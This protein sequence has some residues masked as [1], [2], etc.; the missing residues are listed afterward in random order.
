[1]WS[2]EFRCK[3]SFKT[4][5][6]PI[7]CSF[8]GFLLFFTCLIVVLASKMFASALL[9]VLSTLPYRL[10]WSLG[11]SDPIPPLDGGVFREK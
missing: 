4:D 2:G 5:F 11:R 9:F 3:I 10:A 8:F 7:C 6:V 1:M